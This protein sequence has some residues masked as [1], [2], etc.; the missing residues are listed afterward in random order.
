MMLPRIPRPLRINPAGRDKGKEASRGAKGYATR[1]PKEGLRKLP[2]GLGF[3]PGFW[4]RYSLYEV[5]LLP[6]SKQ[7]ELK[8]QP[9]R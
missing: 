2:S 8:P 1:E 6:S 7:G 3:C 4:C 5:L 9:F